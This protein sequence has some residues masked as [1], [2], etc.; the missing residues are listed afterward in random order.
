MQS[1]FGQ[2]HPETTI[3]GWAFT[4]T[5]FY[6]VE[7]MA[8]QLRQAGHAVGTRRVR[9]LLRLMGLMAVYPKPRLSVPGTVAN[10]WP[11][12]LGSL[13]PA[14]PDVAWATDITYIR[15][16]RGFCYLCATMDWHSRAVLAWRLSTSLEGSFCLDTCATRWRPTAACPSAS[17]PTRAPSSPVPNT[18]ACCSATASSRHGTAAD[19]SWTTSSSSGSGARSNTSASSSTSGP[20]PATRSAGCGNTSISTTNSGRTLRLTKCRLRRFISA[21]LTT[22]ARRGVA[23]PSRSSFGRKVGG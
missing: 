2:I 5:P 6:G 21:P 19:G 16:Q 9:R 17:T 15:L 7:R 3:R 22:P 11:Y 23:T 12:L 1:Q 8:W 10:A 13:K 14:Q 4:A 18:P 20:A